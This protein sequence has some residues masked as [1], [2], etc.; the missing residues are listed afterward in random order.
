MLNEIM[1]IVDE[2]RHISKLA[3]LYGGQVD[4]PDP[5]NDVDVLF[6]IEEGSK[7]KIISQIQSIQRN[8]KYLLHPVLVSEEAF[9]RNPYFSVL[10]KDGVRLW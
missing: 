7:G 6:V 3:Y 9:E 2:L 5:A 1:N 10:V 4:R 8:S